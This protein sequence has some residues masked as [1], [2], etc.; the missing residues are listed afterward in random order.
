MIE[1]IKQEAIQRINI[2]E[3]HD[4]KKSDQSSLYRSQAGTRF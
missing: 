4:I 1:A 2:E 3:Y